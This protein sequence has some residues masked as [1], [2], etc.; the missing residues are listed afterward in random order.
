MNRLHLAAGLAAAA[1]LFT[2]STASAQ[3]DSLRLGVM[4]H[5]I[6]VTDGKNADKES[7]VNI[8][9]EVSFASPRLLRAIGSPHPFLV[10]SVNTDGNT[11][12]AGAG[13]GWDVRLGGGWRIEPG[14]GYVVHDGEVENPFPSNTPEAVEFSSTRVLLG[15]RDL[16]RSSLAVTRDFGEEWAV[17]L[18]Y[19][20]LSHGQILGTGR[21]QGLDEIGVRLVRRFR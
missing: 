6:R 12:F 18:L 7:G 9:G 17:Q 13:I 11:S 21:N 5:N 20:H 3:V 19:E 15:S 14:F 10:A 8:H 16:F 4:D 1:S 2:A